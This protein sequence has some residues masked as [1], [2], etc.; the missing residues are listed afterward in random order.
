MILQQI[1]DQEE[2]EALAKR[3]QEGTASTSLINDSEIAGA[4]WSMTTSN[5]QGHGEELEDDEAM[6]RRLA[7][8]WAAMDSSVR[9]TNHAQIADTGSTSTREGP[10]RVPKDAANTTPP[11]EQLSEYKDLF[12]GERSCT[13]C[14]GKVRS[15]QGVVCL[16]FLVVCVHLVTMRLD[17]F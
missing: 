9:D 11:D 12:T 15:P 10:L 7:A 16:S 17:Y 4:G 8:E 5:C 1:K 6:A 3:L 14:G 2:S 13:S